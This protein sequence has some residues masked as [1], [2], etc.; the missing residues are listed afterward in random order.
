[1]KQR[2]VKEALSALEE[3]LAIHQKLD[4]EPN[5]VGGL[6]AE[7]MKKTF[8]KAGLVI[9]QYLN[10]VH[11]P[12]ARA[13]LEDT[14]EKAKAYA[15]EKVVA[16]GKGD[17]AMA[18]YDTLGRQKD[19]YRYAQEVAQETL[20]DAEKFG[21]VCVGQGKER[22]Y[23]AGVK[24]VELVNAVDPR[25]LWDAEEKCFVM[26]ETAKAL[27]VTGFMRWGRE[28]FAQCVIRV[29]VNGE[30]AAKAEGPDV[31]D[32]NY[33]NEGVLLAC[34]VKGGDKVTLELEVESSSGAG[35]AVYAKFIK[36]E[37]LL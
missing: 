14:L 30:E 24:Q 1:M 12:E 10:E 4:D 17:M 8:D 3:D 37:I 31:S 13:A 29:K 15:D 27:L 2:Q 25:G 21:Y 9:Q 36:T 23:K 35:G 7:E 5:D 33:Y 18:V 19:V 20:G 22:Q 28:S 16:V 11:L 34:Q 6:S 32:G 26:P